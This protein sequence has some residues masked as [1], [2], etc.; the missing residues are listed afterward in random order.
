M[1]DRATIVR[2]NAA[3]TP[4]TEDRRDAQIRKL[5]SALKTLQAGLI[6]IQ[7]FGFEG[8]QRRNTVADLRTA[9][10]ALGTTRKPHPDYLG[11]AG[12]LAVRDGRVE[13]VRR[14]DR[15]PIRCRTRITLTPEER[16]ALGSEE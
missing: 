8:R 3:H 15:H 10:L 9:D 16:Y 6:D 2:E 7:N 1:K 14:D 5:T 12:M 4:S 13:Q 11:I